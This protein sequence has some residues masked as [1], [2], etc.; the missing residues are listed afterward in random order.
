MKQ[1]FTN[2]CVSFIFL[3]IVVESIYF[4]K[5]LENTK[6]K[7]VGKSATLVCEISK[8]GLK[9]DWYHGKNKIR[10]GEDYD[11]VADG[12]THKLVIEKVTDEMVGEYRAEYK[13]AKTTCQLS[14]AGKILVYSLLIT[15]SR[16]IFC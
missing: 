16:N 13:T 6:V 8:D 9:V 11:I 12:K 1:S 10:R 14:L 7:D 2:K 4:T 15:K 5:E 3:F